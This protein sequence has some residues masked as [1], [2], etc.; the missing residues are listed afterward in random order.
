MPPFNCM[1]LE[2]ITIKGM[3]T[4]TNMHGILQ[5]LLSHFMVL[6]IKVVINIFFFSFP[7]F[8]PRYILAHFICSPLYNK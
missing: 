4:I 7:L 8:P 3:N 1:C 5:V 2:G 6:D